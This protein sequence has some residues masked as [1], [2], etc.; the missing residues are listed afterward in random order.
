MKIMKAESSEMTRLCSFGTC[1]VRS[2][3]IVFPLHKCP[4][5]GGRGWYKTWTLRL[6]LLLD[7]PSSIFRRPKKHELV[8]MHWIY[9]NLPLRSQAM[10][11]QATPV[12]CSCC[13]FSFFVVFYIAFYVFGASKMCGIG[14]R[15]GEG[16]LPQIS[17]VRV[18]RRQEYHMRVIGRIRIVQL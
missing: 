8:N 13:I 6:D 5:T 9:S 16:V 2:V 12:I 11:R 7:F 10:C 14:A 4:L 3:R 18:P 17:D 1:R 15:G